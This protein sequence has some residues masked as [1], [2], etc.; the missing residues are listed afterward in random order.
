LALA[1]QGRF[2][3]ATKE[4]QA[5]LNLD[6][7]NSKAH[8]NLGLIYDRQNRP[9]DALRELQMALELEPNNAKIHYNLGVTLARGGRT[10]EAKKAF[11]NAIKGGVTTAATGPGSANVIGGVFSVVKLH[12]NRIDDMIVKETLAMKCAFGENPKRVYND[13]KMTP[14]TRMGT[15]AK[16]RE[17]LAKTVEYRDKKL[18]AAGDAS[19]MPTYDMKLEAMLPV[20]NKEIPLKAHAHR[21]DDIFTSIR[22]A[23]EF[24]VLLTL[25]H[26]TEGHLIADQL[27]KE[28]YPAIIGPSFGNKSKFELNQKTFDTP[29]IMHKAG[30]KIA[31][32]TDSPVIPLEYLPMCAALAHKAGLDEMEALKCISINAAEILGVDERIGSIAV[33]KDADLV[34]WNGHPFDLQATVSHTLVNGKVVY[35]K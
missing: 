23:K 22:I 27:A 30:V 4:F 35:Q 17:T 28:G 2:D 14:S 12:G 18:A 21:A 34:I 19:K 26:C 13:K 25:E 11:E 6:P 8:L 33:G 16:L 32:M 31:I 10:E 9:E 29:G 15:A 5:T 20:I 1:R 24:D 3:E 7:Q